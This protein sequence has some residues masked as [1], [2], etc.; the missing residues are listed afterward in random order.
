MG[1][2]DGSALDKLGTEL[3]KL[4]ETLGKAN[5]AFPATRAFLESKGV[6]SVNDLDSEGRREL[7]LHLEQELKLALTGR[8]TPS[9][10]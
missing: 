6:A 3:E 8:M 7:K 2:K 5:D 9:E 1:Q 4:S 10:A